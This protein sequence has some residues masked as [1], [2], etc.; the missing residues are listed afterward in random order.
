MCIE[1]LEGFGQGVF[2]GRSTNF[3]VDARGAHQIEEFGPAMRMR[4]SQVG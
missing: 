4:G 3:A 1:I 2:L